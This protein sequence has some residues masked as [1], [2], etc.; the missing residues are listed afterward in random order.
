MSSSVISSITFIWLVLI[1]IVTWSGLGIELGEHV[2]GVIG[3]PFRVGAFTFGSK[4]DRSADLQDH[5]RHR[6]AQSGQQF[7][8]LRKP[9]AAFA[10]E[11]A[12]VD[13]QDGGTGL[14]AVDGLLHVLFDGQREILGK[15]VDLHSGP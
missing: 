14:V 8:E 15:V 12:D 10:V 7:V 6:L 13:V 2:A 5:V 11:L 3:Q 9:L 1:A 4:R